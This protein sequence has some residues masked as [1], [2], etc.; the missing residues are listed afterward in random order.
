MSQ[1]KTLSVIILS[2]YS[3][4]RL[5]VAYERISQ[6]FQENQIPFEFIVID[7]GSA[8]NSFEVAQELEKGN[9]NVRAFQL[10]RNYTSHYAV[11]AGL[12]VAAGACCTFVPD[13]EQ[14]PYFSLVE[15]YRLWEEG[16]KVI[17][18]HRSN[19]KDSFL[20]KLG[21]SF[22][23]KIFNS[24]SDVKFP[25]G[26]ADSF[27]IDREII[28]IVNKHISPRRT[29]T[30]TEILRLG[31]NPKYLPY[32]RVKGINRK[33][34]WTL[35][36]KI[37][38]AKDL[39]YSSSSWPI[40]FITNLGITCFIFSF[41]AVA[42]LIYARFFGNDK[43]WNLKNFPG[44]TSTVVIVAFFSGLILLSLGIIAEYISRIFDEVKGRPGYLIKMKDKD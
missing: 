20:S 39:L 13:D 19:R 36:K 18:P 25:V 16:N 32:S 8:D 2:Y 23:Y 31:F 17:I 29:T 43:F 11:F 34:R 6:V 21:S 4:Q 37:N 28:D 9:A 42:I 44:W 26:G 15:M 30:I 5:K 3:G 38:L 14:Q 40:K 22:F 33:S 1:N 12:S 41:V 10:S 35:K 27:F 24:I 7:D